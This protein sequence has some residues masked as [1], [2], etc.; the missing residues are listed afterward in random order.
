MSFST[1]LLRSCFSP[2]CFFSRTTFI[3]VNS[4]VSSKMAS[5]HKSCS[6]LS[7]IA[8]SLAPPRLSQQVHRYVPKAL[9]VPIVSLLTHIPG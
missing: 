9:D 1:L 8:H 3:A 6:H 7:D 4:Q 5:Q 2:C